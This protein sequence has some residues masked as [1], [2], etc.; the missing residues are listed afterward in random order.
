MNNNRVAKNAFWIISCRIVQAVLNLIIAMIS[1]RYLGPSNY[2]LINYAASVV[3]FAVPIMYL[4]INNILVQEIVNHPKKEGEILGTSIVLSFT[5]AILCMTGIFSFVSIMNAGEKDTI[6]VCVLYSILLLF[7]SIDLIQYWF[8]AKLLSKYTS[9]IMLAAYIM[10]SLYK[11]YLLISQKSV[12][13][14]ALSTAFDYFIVAVF[15]L[16]IYRKLGG[17]KLTFS[18]SLAKRLA[19]KGRYYIVSGLMITIFAQT[20]KVMIKLMIGE[21]E[22]GY[23]SA[24]VACAGMTSFVFTALIDSMRPVIFEKK[25][26]GEAEY[27]LNITR[28]YSIVIYLSLLQSAC[29]TIFSKYIILILYGNAYLPAIS[30]LRIIVWYTTFS[31]LGAVRDIWLLAEDKQRY[32]WMINLFGAS[33]N[34]LLN[35]LLIPLI[36]INGA[37]IASLVTQIFTNI[38]VGYIIKPIRGNNRLMVKSLNYKIL[39]SFIK[40]LNRRRQHEKL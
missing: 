4:G 8:Q 14:F 39:F 30:A 25:M 15:S 29:I 1:A 7:Q 37:A 3:A 36:G 13:W 34:V 40:N 12:F 11:I 2:G 24:A 22:V 19:A 35:F 31:Y 23:Y 5:S 9:L 10:M 28:L 38:I 32:L 6:L 20:D 26:E 16:I 17:Q 33:A 21:S 18:F 27:E